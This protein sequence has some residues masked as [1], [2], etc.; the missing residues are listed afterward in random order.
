[1]LI[2]LLRVLT[3]LSWV[4]WVIALILVYFFFKSPE[5]EKQS[6]SPPVS[7]LKPIKGLDSQAYENFASFCR[8]DYPEFEILFGVSD[9]GDAVIPIIHRIQKDFPQLSIRLLVDADE[10]PNQKAGLLH[11]L[12]SQASNEILV[13]SDSDMHVTPDYLRRVVAP[14]AN[15]EIGLVTCPY[16]GAYPVTFT[17]RLEALYMGVTFLPATIVGRKV[18]KMRFALGAT[19]ALR[20]SDLERFGGFAA[21]SGYLADDYQLGRKITQLGLRVYLSQYVVRSVLGPTTFEEQW[22]REIRWMHCTRI[23]RPLEYPGLLLSFTTPLALSLVILSSFAVAA[24]IFLL[25]SLVLRWVVALAITQYT[26]DET[27]RKWIFWL[28]L[29]D[30]L[31]ALI[32]TVSLLGNKVTWR[33][34]QY[35]LQEDGSMV[36]V[37][38]RKE[39][40]ESHADI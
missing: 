29:R 33:G 9:P 32:W 15:H 30:L 18:I 8:Q 24:W 4:Y 26:Q 7:I 1:M 34:Q 21:L 16:S 14:L 22:Q 35:I 23:S 6:F 31:T 2:T 20:K 37:A 25:V 12:S 5:P 17:A 28:P 38:A 3:V 13:A 36:P 11:T 27:S 39:T 19:N 40:E 10:K